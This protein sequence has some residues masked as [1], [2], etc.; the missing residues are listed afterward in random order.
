M[1]PDIRPAFTVRRAESQYKAA[2]EARRR[3]EAQA[4][5]DRIAQN[6]RSQQQAQEAQRA[7][8]SPHRSLREALV[9]FTDEW[10]ASYPTRLH[11]AFSV[12]ADAV[13]GSP[14]WTERWKAWMNA[15]DPLRDKD[16]PPTVE[17]I[18]RAHMALTMSES[19]WDRCAAAFLF[20]L[21]CLGFDP[22]AAGR[23]M[24]SPLPVEYTAGYTEKAIDRLREKV[25][26]EHQRPPG[27]VDRPEWMDR[28]HIG[29][30]ESQHE[31]EAA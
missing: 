17:P 20:R 1:A 30:S 16:A 21:A 18:R 19:L 14:A 8:S 6:A 13:L 27:K 4:E 25:A 2:E 7:L 5:T 12:E 24:P 23:N 22:L 11:E 15:N 9:W 29:K 10:Q 31:A 26:K 3:S 28:L